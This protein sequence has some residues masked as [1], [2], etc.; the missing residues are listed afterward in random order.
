M[1]KVVKYQTL[2][3]YYTFVPIAIE[4]LGPMGPEAKTFLL[5]LGRRL[6]QQTG[7]TADFHGH[8]EGKCNRHY[9]I[10]PT[11]GAGG[12]IRV[13]IVSSFVI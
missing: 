11:G 4:T 9:G 13:V 6:R 10:N 5:E 8:P 12:T 7:I 2:A 1:R 3:V